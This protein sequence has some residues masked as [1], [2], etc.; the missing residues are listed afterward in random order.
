MKANEISSWKFK[1]ES[2]CPIATH[3]DLSFT[4]EMRSIHTSPHYV[5]YLNRQKEIYQSIGDDDIFERIEQ[6]EKLFFENV[7]YSSDQESFSLSCEYDFQISFQS[8]YTVYD[9]KNY[10]I[11]MELFKTIVKAYLYESFGMMNDD[12]SKLLK[13]L[14]I[15]QDYSLKKIS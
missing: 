6:H 14:I 2:F 10:V 9:I 1:V 3:N 4:N 13:N 7:K 11:T 8:D 15:N 5:S 12:K